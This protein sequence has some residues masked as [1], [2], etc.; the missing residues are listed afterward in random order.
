MAL[1]IIPIGLLARL[2]PACILAFVFTGIGALA[3]S[4]ISLLLVYHQ[5]YYWLLLALPLFA[6]AIWIIIQAA[7]RKPGT[8]RTSQ[9]ASVSPGLLTTILILCL[10]SGLAIGVVISI[11]LSQ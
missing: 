6:L 5:F 1:I 7:K 8:R 9:A 11:G 4:T 10:T 2:L 3:G